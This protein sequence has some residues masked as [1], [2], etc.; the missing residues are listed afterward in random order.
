[1]ALATF[2]CRWQRGI[3]IAAALP[4]AA[5]AFLPQQLIL[6]AALLPQCSMAM[7]N[8]GED[9]D[10]AMRMSLYWMVEQRSPLR[11][12]YESMFSAA[13]RIALI[14]DNEQRQRQL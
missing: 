14:V 9:E 10:D 8:E 12:R 7:V 11:S 3:G 5:A 13:A 2:R 1:M 4:R 6:N